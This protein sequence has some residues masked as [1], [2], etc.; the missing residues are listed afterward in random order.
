MGRIHKGGNFMVYRKTKYANIAI[1]LLF[2]VLSTNFLIY[3]SSVQDY[4]S[5]QLN[6][7]AVVGS[8]IDLAI[9]VPLLMYAA[10]K[11][12]I[13]QTIGIIVAGLVIARIF[14]PNEFFPRLLEYFTQAS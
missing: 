4:L 10:F 9:V 6:T 2:L 5:L 7:G 11:L 12:S 8:L 3:Q 1:A 13:K 14:I